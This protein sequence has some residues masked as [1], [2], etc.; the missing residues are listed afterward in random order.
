MSTKKLT[1]V[2]LVYRPVHDYEESETPYFVCLT[3]Q[4]AKAC[5]DKMNSFLDRL[6]KRLPSTDNSGEWTEEWQARWDRRQAILD[7]AR[8]PFGIDLSGDI[9]Q[10]GRT[11]TVEVKPLKVIDMRRYL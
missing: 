5:A 10:A 4:E 9:Y 11:N 2:W 6:A 3:E 1:Q 8:W 7:K